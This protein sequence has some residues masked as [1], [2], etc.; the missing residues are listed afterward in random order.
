MNNVHDEK[1]VVRKAS[2]FPVHGGTTG[3]FDCFF[4]NFCLFVCNRMLWLFERDE[5]KWFELRFC[6]FFSNFVITMQR[7]KTQ[8][9]TNTN[10]QTNNDKLQQRL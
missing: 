1:G 9:K 4:T 7:S 6:A 8:T 3:M 5:K 10:K 2:G